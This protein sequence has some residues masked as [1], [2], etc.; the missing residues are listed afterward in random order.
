[1]TKINWLVGT[2]LLLIACTPDTER[3][4][5]VADVPEL[6]NSVLEPAAELYWD[7][8]G[9]ILDGNGVREIQPNN[10]AE[11]EEVRSAAF[12]I[13]ESGN[14]L[15]MDGRARD[16]GDWTAL[17]EALIE[18]GQQA[19]KAADL[20]DA[21]AVFDAGAEVYYACA[22]CHAKYAVETLRPN[23]VRSDTT[24]S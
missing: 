16:R 23:D 10:A 6:M 1:M 18:T 4:T 7:A 21:S 11:W 5:L 14:L 13:A 8:V 12:I 19:I 17:S 9:Y 3:F 15:L 2:A 20:R 22:N 24:S